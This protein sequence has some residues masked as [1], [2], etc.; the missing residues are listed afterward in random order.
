MTPG[1]WYPHPNRTSW[2]HSGI[3][4]G[5]ECVG[6]AV[7]AV[8]GWVIQQGDSDNGGMYFMRK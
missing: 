3:A 8:T 1:P 2:S 4:Q 7:H 5:S 6:E